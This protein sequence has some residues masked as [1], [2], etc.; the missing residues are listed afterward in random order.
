MQSIHKKR[1]SDLSVK[2]LQSLRR[3]LEKHMDS[4]DI[5]SYIDAE[6]YYRKII[7]IVEQKILKGIMRNLRNQI[8]KQ[9]LHDK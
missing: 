8:F 3:R 7:D 5:F 6:I 1:L 9:Q 4:G 2:E